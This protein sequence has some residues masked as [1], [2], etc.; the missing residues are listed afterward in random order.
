MITIR[1]KQAPDGSWIASHHGTVD[2]RSFE[3]RGATEDEAIDALY[4]ALANA[5]HQGLVKAPGHPVQGL[6][7][8]LVTN[9]PQD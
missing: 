2:R 4:V 8:S 1:T 9:P 6:P 3:G 7:R 5:G